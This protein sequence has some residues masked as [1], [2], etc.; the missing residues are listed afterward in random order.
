MRDV[1]E[2]GNRDIL[3][4]NTKLYPFYAFLFTLILYAVVLSGADVLGNGLHLLEYSDWMTQHIPFIMQMGEVI[5]GKHSLWYSWN[6]GLGSGSIGSYA[7]YTFSPFNVFYWIL[8]EDGKHIASA[9]VVTLKAA[10]SALT[11]QIFVNSFLRRTYYETILFSSLYALNGFAVSY[12]HSI[13]SLDAVIIFPVIMFGIIL[14]VRKNRIGILVFAY[15]YLFFTSVYMGYVAGISSFIIFLFCFFYHGKDMEKKNKLRIFLRYV[16][17]V[18]LS[19]GL[20]AILWIP[21]VLNLYELRNSDELYEYTIN[22]NPIMLL[23]NMLVGM[24]QSIEGVIPYYYCGLLTVMALPLFLINKRIGKRKRLYHA[25]CILTFAIIILVPSFNYAMHGFDRPNGVGFRYAF[26]LSFILVTVLC[27]QYVFMIGKNGIGKRFFVVFLFSLIVIFFL[28]KYTI[29][30]KIGKDADSNT[31]FTLAVNL[32]LCIML[33]CTIKG[34]K[35]DRWDKR[36]KKVFFTTVIILELISNIVLIHLRISPKQSVITDEQ[37]T[38]A[39]QNTIRML[40]EESISDNC[41]RTIYQDRHIINIAMENDLSSLAYFSSLING[42]IINMLQKFGY[43]YASN[44]INGNGW[45]PV[46]ASLFGID[47]IVDGS[48][49]LSDDPDIYVMPGANEHYYQNYIK[50]ETPL[51]LVFTVKTDILDYVSEKSALDNQDELLCKM[52]GRKI[53][54]FRPVDMIINS[55]NTRDVDITETEEGVTIINNNYPNE[56]AE[57]I[58]STPYPVTNDVYVN[59]YNRFKVYK[60]SV[61]MIGP[62][63]S[64]DIDV[65]VFNSTTH[66]IYPNQIFKSG[67]KNANNSSFVMHIPA[68]MKDVEYEK[69]YFMEFDSEKFME[70]YEELRANGMEITDFKDGYIGGIVNC[71]EDCVLFSSIPYEKGWTAYVDGVKTNVV[72]LVEDAFVGIELSQGD[73]DIILEYIAP[74]MYAGRWVTLGT[75]FLLLFAKSVSRKSH[76]KLAAV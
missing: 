75:V 45:T 10:T 70:V 5:K 13:H 72:P 47:Y 46:T 44:L 2:K 64:A 33:F 49:L 9:L 68:E 15:S 27:E 38:V 48:C 52:T 8:G 76:L 24:Y 73:H 50:N 20:T 14:L 39:E 67:N 63:V 43:E 53:D 51:P 17:S 57:L 61:R 66:R 12:Y 11:F 36:T 16:E 35:F 18:L 60:D 29:I 62:T 30:K 42:R 56:A 37:Y 55:G 69:G 25:A 3:S 7:Y 31:L 23:N 4:I 28:G 1:K 34:Y 41:I 59:L 54:C 65:N 58:Y 32:I 21:N 6:F 40:K 19:L 74:G 71:S 26:V 22:C